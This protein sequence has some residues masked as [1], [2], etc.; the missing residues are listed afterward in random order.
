MKKI[1]IILILILEISLFIYSNDIIIEFKNTINICLYSL[2]PTM[3]F[4][5]F[6][7]NFLLLNNFYKI[8]PSKH[9][10]LYSVIILSILSGYPNNIKLLKNS[11]N[12]YLNYFTNFVN[13]IFFIGT[14]NNIYLKN[15]ELSILILIS[16][17]ISSIILLIIFRKKYINTNIFKNNNDSIETTYFKSIKNTIE[18]LSIIFSNLLFISLLITLLKLINVNPFIIGL[19]E[20]SK[21]IY[22]ISISNYSYF[23]KGLLILIII[24][25]GSFSIHFQII[26]IND[27]IKYIKFLLF[28]IL[29]V[30]I[31]IIIFLLVYKIYYLIKIYI[32]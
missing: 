24:T 27:K 16:H 2:M 7:S 28:R 25:F 32:Y 23:L 13:P 30:L 21:G 26:S 22:E 11:N 5:I 18:T 19:L 6:F 14:V 15:I 31:S 10:Q 1:L 4:S 20:F 8:I 12:E 17:Y 9:N 3:F 29:N